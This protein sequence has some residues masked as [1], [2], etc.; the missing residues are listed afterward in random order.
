MI[1]IGTRRIA[2]SPEQNSNPL[3]NQQNY[4]V[5]SPPATSSSL[6]PGTSS[7]LNNSS[8]LQMLASM[9]FNERDIHEAMI[10]SH[11]IEEAIEY[12]TSS[13]SNNH[14]IQATNR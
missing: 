10:R 5:N 4:Q 3:H 6:S 12:L 14:P 11:T 8:T 1:I 13:T 2:P 7:G 9:G